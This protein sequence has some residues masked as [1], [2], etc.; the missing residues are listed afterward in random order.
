MMLHIYRLSTGQR[1]LFR[2]SELPGPPKYYA[3]RRSIELTTIYG[4]TYRVM[5]IAP[6]ELVDGTERKAEPGYYVFHWTPTYEG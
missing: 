4:S 3:A 2:D 1:V 5:S 6:E